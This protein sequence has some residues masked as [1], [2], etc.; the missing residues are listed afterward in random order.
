MIIIIISLKFK[1]FLN[2]TNYLRNGAFLKGVG[3]V[4]FEL[5]KNIKSRIS[6]MHNLTTDYLQM[7]ASSKY[8]RIYKKYGLFRNF[9]EQIIYF[10]NLLQILYEERK[11]YYSEFRTKCFIIYICYI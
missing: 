6:S 11:E 1:K 8:K 3:N 4:M 10:H 5:I 7:N 9:L 2:F